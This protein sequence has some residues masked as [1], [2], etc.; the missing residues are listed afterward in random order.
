MKTNIESALKAPQKRPASAMMGNN[1]MPSA[2]SV[3]LQS[4]MGDSAKVDESLW[5]SSNA[6]PAA[7]AET[8]D[9]AKNIK[10][11]EPPPHVKRIPK[12][13]QLEDFKK[14]LVEFIK[15]EGSFEL[16]DPNHE[17]LHQLDVEHLF[18]DEGKK[19]TKVLYHAVEYVYKNLYEDLITNTGDLKFIEWCLHF[20]S[21]Y[22]ADAI[23]KLKE[24]ITIATSS[25]GDSVRVDI[26]RPC[27]GR[28]GKKSKVS[29]D[30]MAEMNRKERVE[31][32][33]KMINDA[34]GTLDETCGKVSCVSE[35][36]LKFVSMQCKMS[37]FDISNVSV[38]GAQF[39][40]GKRLFIFTKM[41]DAASAQ[42]LT[43]EGD[44][45][46]MIVSSVNNQ[47]TGV[48]LRLSDVV[49]ICAYK[50]VQTLQAYQRAK[51]GF[52]VNDG[53]RK[54]G[55]VAI[56]IDSIML[57]PQLSSQYG[58]Q[59][60]IKLYPLRVQ[61]VDCSMFDFTFDEDDDDE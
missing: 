37:K 26:K 41:H 52:M 18:T 10:L 57:S 23:L 53:V 35:E 9:F 42:I 24:F 25:C 51:N 50:K 20:L 17:T 8:V 45:R 15:E 39:K 31:A 27:L 60:I 12:F 61:K 21:I 34:F 32:W 38:M 1:V 47:V 7:S 2:R 36:N 16:N 49:K 56:L 55:N 46:D 54:S 22:T 3:D 58:D 44:A 33:L 11:I 14:A 6:V 59:N 19:A 29:K 5:D 30:Q 28:F 43:L 48:D 4:V 40:F 13:V